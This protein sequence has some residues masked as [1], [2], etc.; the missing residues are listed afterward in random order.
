MLTTLYTVNFVGIRNPIQV[1][2]RLM[3]EE[4]K[5]AMPRGRIPPM[6]V[7]HVHVETTRLHGV[8]SAGNNT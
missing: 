6:Y 5:G 1:A 2:A 7:T 4:V 8:M 3:H